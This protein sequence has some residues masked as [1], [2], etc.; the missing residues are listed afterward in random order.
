MDWLF[1]IFR[2]LWRRLESGIAEELLELALKGMSLWFKICKEFRRNIDGFNGRYQFR[3][4]NNSVTVGALFTG[5]GLKVKEGLIKD[6]DVSVIFK[7]GKSLRTLVNYFLATD[8]DIMKLMFNN[9]VELKG[10]LNYMLKF[11]YMTNH[12]LLPL[13]RL[14]LR[15]TGRLP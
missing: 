2:K 10:N 13:K 11:S 5:K 3:S 12:L 15:L 14:L 1:N 9:G 4:A 6:A 8:P 7:D